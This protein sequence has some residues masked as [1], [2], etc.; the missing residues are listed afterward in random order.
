MKKDT[1][2]YDYVMQDVLGNVSGVTS[3]AMFGGWGLYKDSVI[4]A[5]IVEDELFFKV[6]DG[7]RADFEKYGSRPFTYEGKNGKHVTMSYWLLPEEVLENTNELH[8]WLEQAV[9]ASKRGKKK[10]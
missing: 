9:M 6:D 8:T 3:R 5:I 2:F 1:S 4:F 10:K 7:N